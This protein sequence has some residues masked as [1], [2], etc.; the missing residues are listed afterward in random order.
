MLRWFYILT[1]YITRITNKGNKKQKEGGKLNETHI[2]GTEF[3]G[4]RHCIAF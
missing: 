3:R 1:S 4:L 2:R